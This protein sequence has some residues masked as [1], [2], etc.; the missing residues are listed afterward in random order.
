M[1]QN[2]VA[3]GSAE[4]IIFLEI[5]FCLAQTSIFMTSGKKIQIPALRFLK[6]AREPVFFSHLW[7]QFPALAEFL[8]SALHNF[9]PSSPSPIFFP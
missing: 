6:I 7:L 4:I 8:F 3:Q 2:G 1:L 9:A 5:Y